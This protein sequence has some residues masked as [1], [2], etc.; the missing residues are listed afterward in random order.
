MYIAPDTVIKILKDCPLDTSYTHT[1]YFSSK[2]AQQNYFVG[3]EKFKLTA[4]TYQRVQRGRMRVE[5]KAEDLYDCNYLMFQNSSFGN[6]WFYAFIT[7]VEYVNNITSEIAFQIDVMQTWHFD[8]ELQQ[9][10]VEREHVT[11]DAIGANL[12]PEPVDIGEYT[13]ESYS[14]SGV[15]NTPCIVLVSNVNAEGTEISGG[16]AAGIWHGQAYTPYSMTESGWNALVER[17]KSFD[18]WDTLN[19]N[20]TACFMYYYE[21]MNN[22]IITPTSPAI[23]NIM[24]PKKYG[25]LGG[26]TP[27]NNK[28]YTYPYNYLLI[29]NDSG[30]NVEIKYEFFSGSSC[31][32]RIAGDVSANPQ[33]MCEPTNYKNTVFLRNERIILS[34]FPQCTYNIDAF[35]AWLAQTASNPDVLTNMAT[36]AVQ[37]GMTGGVTGA[38][39]GAGA[40]LLGTAINGAIA[41]I[42]PPTVKG[43]VHTDISFAVGTKDFFFYPTHAHP[44]YLKRIDNFFDVFGYAVNMHKIPNRSARPYWNYVKCTDVNITGSVPADDANT[45]VSIYEKGITFWK[46]GNN[47][48][49]YSL[50]NSP[51]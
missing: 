39:G 42:S 32:F 12:Q 26:Y 17:M 51:T 43:T 15:M 2:Q 21:F 38:A 9:C 23:Y 25:S 27:R 7:G 4:Q 48:G 50:N 29:T 6:K 24:K 31:T 34:G 33:V 18:S 28:L 14:G 30:E 13:Y 45:I 37:G 20:V 41:Y 1:I 19:E 3:L 49:N 10:F 47:I 44:D 5:I 36:S 46:N 16:A 22:D 11:N 8:Y 35:K 40:Q